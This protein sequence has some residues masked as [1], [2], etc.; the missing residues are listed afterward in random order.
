MIRALRD[1]VSYTFD[2]M[3]N[4][5]QHEEALRQIRMRIG[6]VLPP[7][8]ELLVSIEIEPIADITLIES[9]DRDHEDLQGL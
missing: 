8:N 1:L 5:E 3:Y 6:E 2:E 7:L 4:E 9:A